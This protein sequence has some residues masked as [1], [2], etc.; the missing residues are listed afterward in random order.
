M[1]FG[2]DFNSL[3]RIYNSVFGNARWRIRRL[4]YFEDFDYILQINVRG[5]RP[6]RDNKKFNEFDYRS[7]L[8]IL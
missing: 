6:E 4:L 7:N 3:L 5:K 2:L 8:S 1:F